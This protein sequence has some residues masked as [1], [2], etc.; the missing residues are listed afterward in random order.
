MSQ[1]QPH[2]IAYRIVSDAVTARLKEGG[3]V[4]IEVPLNAKGQLVF[5][6]AIDRDLNRTGIPALAKDSLKETV[7]ERLLLT[8]PQDRTDDLDV[9][10]VAGTPGRKAFKI[11]KAQ[12]GSQ[13]PHFRT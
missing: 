2:E 10:P 7:L 13:A 8:G 5:S 3:E 1:Q 4:V 12:P 6:D 11:T 9:V